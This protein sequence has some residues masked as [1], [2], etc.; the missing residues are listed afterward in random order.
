MTRSTSAHHYNT[1]AIVCSDNTRPIDVVLVLDNASFSKNHFVVIM[2]IATTIW[3][4][5]VAKF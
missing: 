1:P 3:S 5:N 2:V 4:E